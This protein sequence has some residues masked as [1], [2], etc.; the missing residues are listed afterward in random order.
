MAR[1]NRTRHVNPYSYVGGNP[2]TYVDPDGL[3]VRISGSP[4]FQ[5]AVNTELDSL[6]RTPS[7]RQLFDA[8]NDSRRIHTITSTTGGN[9]CAPSSGYVPGS[10]SGSTIRFN[11]LNTRCGTDAAGSNARPPYV[12]LGHEMGHS[13]A[14]D[15]GSQT[16]D[17]GSGSP[18]TTPPSEI[19]SIRRE[20]QIR[21][22]NG[23]P[24]RPSYY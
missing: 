7:G 23:L 2:L 11:P 19:N 4:P 18:G 3:V 1:H 8:L 17:R 22:E 14:I 20:N 13:E 5:R 15:A 21:R 16:F 10:G 12:G 24:I 9:S 6:R